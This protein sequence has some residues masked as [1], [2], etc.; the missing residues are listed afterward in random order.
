[1]S[2]YPIDSGF[3]LDCARALVRADSENPPG[4]ER[5]V[6]AEAARFA[7]AAGLRTEIVETAPRRC[8]LVATL[9]SGRP[10]PTLLWNGH[11]DVVPAADP[12]A[13]TYPPYEAVVDD[14]VLH[15][16]GSA[17]MKGGCAA[18]IAAA[19]TLRAAGGPQAGRL[20]L[21]LVADEEVLGP[22]GTR[23]LYERGLVEAD[24]AIV[25]EPT[26]L[27]VA[28]AERG[29]LWVIART[30]GV[31]A[32][33][34]QPHLGRS[35]I[36]EMATVVLALRGMTWKRPHPLLG[37]P[38]LNV[39]I[40]RGGS[41]INIVP[42]ACEI[43][44]DRRTIP[45]ETG[46]GVLAEMRAAIAAAG[47]SADLEIVH[48]ADPTEVSPQEEIVARAS[49]AHRAV[50]GADARVGVFAGATDAHVLVGR[51]KIPAIVF[52]P[53]SLSQAHAA[54]EHV[55]ISDLDDAAAIY[56]RLFD[57]YLR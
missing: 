33:G 19:A 51:A 29:M 23:A 30:T 10:G 45:G 49:E 27:E 13:W 56:A 12:E 1:M 43:E 4:D 46:D 55:S 11:L 48:H 21:H 57:A 31:A 18:A 20:V 2:E 25:G 24:A 52:G 9:D 53:G 47:A 38:S 35:A 34:S 17:D 15:G 42:A 5:A 54:N 39:G 28:V 44:I 41:K 22:H 32:H 50:R 3:L 8:N 40:V 37:T 26:G 14:G 36:E 6:A 16:R 7:A